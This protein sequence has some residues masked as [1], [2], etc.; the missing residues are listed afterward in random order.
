[1]RIAELE[2]KNEE[3]ER[4]LFKTKQEMRQTGEAR[5]PKKNKDE[6]ERMIQ[7]LTKSNALLRRKLDDALQKVTE[8]ENKKGK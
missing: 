2:E 4:S 3:L 6:Q 8:L 1:M 5:F 7:D